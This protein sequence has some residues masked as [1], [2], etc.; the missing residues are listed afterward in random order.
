MIVG[1]GTRPVNQLVVTPEI[2]GPAPVRIVV[3]LGNESDGCGTV[4]ATSVPY[5]RSML[6]EGMSE[7][8][9]S[10]R[11]PSTMM[12]TTRPASAGPGGGV[13]DSSDCGTRADT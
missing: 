12:S 3:Q 5:V 8:E 9:T 7:R 6:S 11:M 2:V 4:S 1:A 13:V 10:V